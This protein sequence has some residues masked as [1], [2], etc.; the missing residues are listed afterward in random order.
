MLTVVLAFTREYPSLSVRYW[1]RLVE[2]LQ[3]SAHGEFDC[4]IVCDMGSDIRHALLLCLCMC[5]TITSQPAS[6]A[7]PLVVMLYI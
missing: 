3:T 5:C 2:M 1:T 6:S 4:K 7:S